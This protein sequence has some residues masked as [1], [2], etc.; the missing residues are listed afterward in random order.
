MEI[1]QRVVKARTHT[2]NTPKLF[3]LLS[4]YDKESSD[5]QI[6]QKVIKTRTRS[7]GQAKGVAI[8]KRNV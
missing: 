7:D 8:R 3:D 1:R 5:S 6:R 2:Q 4:K